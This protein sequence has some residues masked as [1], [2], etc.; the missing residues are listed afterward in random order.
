MIYFYRILYVV[1][2]PLFVVGIMLSAIPGT[3]LC[4]PYVLYR[5]VRWGKCEEELALL[6]LYPFCIILDWIHER[7]KNEN[8]L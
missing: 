3:L 8:S 1:L 6:W 5:W 7:L 2:I 4:S